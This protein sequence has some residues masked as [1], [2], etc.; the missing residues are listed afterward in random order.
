MEYY[1]ST[2]DMFRDYLG[3]AW[4]T[5]LNDVAGSTYLGYSAETSINE[6][7][8]IA[9]G[10]NSTIDIEL[11]PKSGA[12]KQTGTKTIFKE[13]LINEI[14]SA[15]TGQSSLPGIALAD[16]ESVTLIIYVAGKCSGSNTGW[17][18]IYTATW[19]RDSSTYQLVGE[20]GAVMSNDDTGK[21]HTIST[22]ES[23]GT[24]YV[25]MTSEAGSNNSSWS[26]A[27]HAIFRKDL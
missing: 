26:W 15:T 6:R 4:G 22:S 20:T 19:T 12:V 2:Y 11:V 18:G 9:Q 14:T 16:G 13:V 3:S 5:R 1:N 25:T 8:L 27:C 23:S 7:K 21:T 17:G 24:M 10:N